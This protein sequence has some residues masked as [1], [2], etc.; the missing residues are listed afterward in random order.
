MA[1][2][3]RIKPNDGNLYK[4]ANDM[5]AKASLSVRR[6]AASGFFGQG[7]LAEIS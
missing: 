6:T 2:P 1:T 7:I 5:F 4:R 3:K